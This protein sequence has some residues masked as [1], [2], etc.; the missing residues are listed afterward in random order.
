M[1][2]NNNYIG[3]WNIPFHLTG[4]SEFS[5][6]FGNLNYNNQSIFKEK[7]LENF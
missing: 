3:V 5:G 7:S 4:L 6:T 1:Q 2:V